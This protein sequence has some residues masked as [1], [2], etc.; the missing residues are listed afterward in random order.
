M[1]KTL[2]KT[3]MLDLNLEILFFK[4]EPRT[5]EI[6]IQ[7]KEIYVLHFVKSKRKHFENLDEKNLSVNKIFWS[8]VKSLLSNKTV[9][10]EIITLLEG[11][12]VVDNDKK[13]RQF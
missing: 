3:I 11:K 8:V 13:L 10:D 2:S 1:N 9:S 5:I 12:N 4:T 7:Q 6:I